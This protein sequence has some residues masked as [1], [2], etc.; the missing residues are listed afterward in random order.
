MGRG[1]GNRLIGRIC[2]SS[3]S[4]E[5]STG[6]QNPTTT[7]SG[8][9]HEPVASLFCHGDGDGDRVLIRSHVGDTPGGGLAVRTEPRGLRNDLATKHPSNSLVH[10]SGARRSD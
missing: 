6:P 1:S 5:P 8:S 3:V 7:L 9:C 4:Y 2:G 10:G